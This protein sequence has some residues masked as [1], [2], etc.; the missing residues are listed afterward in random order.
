M[1][2]DDH[3]PPHFHVEYGEFKAVIDIR[4]AE[5]LEGYLPSKQLK[6]TQAAILHEEQL[7]EN[8]E[9]LGK[10]IKSWIKIDPLQ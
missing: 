7:L 5:L 6:L 4:T 9:N 10:D 8:F 1:F 2:F 3:S